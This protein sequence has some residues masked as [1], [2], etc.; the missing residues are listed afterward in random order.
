[1]KQVLRY[2]CMLIVLMPVVAAFG[3]TVSSEHQGIRYP[4]LGDNFTADHLGNIYW[5]AGTRLLRFH[6]HTGSTDSYSNASYGDIRFVDASDPFNILVFHYRSQRVIWLDRNLAPKVSPGVTSFAEKEYFS[7]V[8]GSELGGFWAFHPS[9]ARIMHYDQ[10]FAKKAQTLPLLEI[11]PRFGDPVAI[12]ESDAR[13]FV[14]QPERGIAVFDLFG[15]FAFLIEKT[16][17]ESF[18]V[19]GNNIFFFTKTE[20]ISYNFIRKTHTK[21]MSFNDP[22]MAGLIVGSTVY[23]LSATGLYAFGMNQQ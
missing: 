9:S 12:V 3:Q 10:S 8:A 6:T 14:S 4:V 17:I 16:G 21:V 11:L 7:I 22:I 19:I 20:L 1:M 5:I 23:V 18:Q 13:L 15:N 2:A